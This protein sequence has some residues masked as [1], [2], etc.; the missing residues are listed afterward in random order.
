M[1]RTLA[2]I[3]ADQEALANEA[4][5]LEKAKLEEVAA[6]LDGAEFK[7]VKAKLQSFAADLPVSNTQINLSNTLQ[8]INSAGISLPID[9]QNVASRIPA[10]GGDEE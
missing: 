4:A 1:T 3:K 9:T 10:P 7:A 6:Y 5:I 8:C 2:Q